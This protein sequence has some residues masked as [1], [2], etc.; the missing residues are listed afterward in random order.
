LLKKYSLILISIMFFFINSGCSLNKLYSEDSINKNQDQVEPAKNEQDQKDVK[1]LEDK[2]ETK[3]KDPILEQISK[4]SLEEKIGQMIVVGIEGYN[5]NDNT[6]N[7]IEKYK[8]GG[9][10]LFGENV[11]D[12]NQLLNLLNSIKEENLKNHIPLFLSI[13]EEG[14]QVTRMPKEFKRIPT[15]KAIGQINN[16]TFSYKLGDAIAKEIKS[17]GLNMN[18]APVLDIN[19]NPKNPVIG[20]RSFGSEVD[21]VSRLGIETMKG[22]QSANVIPVVKHFPGHGDTSVDSHKALPSVSSDLERLQS[23]ELIPFGEAVKNGA[24][25]VMIAHILLPNIDKENPSSLS[26]TIITGIL[27]DNLR[28]DGVVITDDMTM[29]AI[30][31]NYNIGEASVKSVEAG[32]DIVLVCHGY[33]NA[34]EVINALKDAV[35]NGKI[36]ERRIEES[37][38]RIL[39]LKK[40]YN[41]KDEI[42]DSVD[43]KKI[44]NDINSLLNTY[45]NK[46]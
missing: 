42:M 8:A 19:S 9:F 20:D 3:P 6:K 32:T 36:S 26:K 39:R 14:G 27:R 45:L 17:F 28:F 4:M 22:I 7:L 16:T 5:L 43:V 1:T 38:Y 44:N 34:V 2:V 10:I 11:Q 23:F 21:I 29:G 15:N 31:K 37:V 24:D 18:F 13:D 33:N 40:K 30:T 25:A 41:L 35:L 12:T 46:K